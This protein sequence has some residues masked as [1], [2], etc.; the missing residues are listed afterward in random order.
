MQGQLQ[1]DEDGLSRGG[2]K[3]HASEQLNQQGGAQPGYTHK[4]NGGM[5]GSNFNQGGEG[6]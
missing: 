6:G 2:D 5:N 3:G 1:P 4:I